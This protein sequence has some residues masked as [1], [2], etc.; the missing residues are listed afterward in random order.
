MNFRARSAAL[1]LA[2]IAYAAIIGSLLPAAAETTKERVL[3][4]G[5]IVIGIHNRAP[6]GYKK[7]GTGELVGWHPD[8]LRAA[9]ADLGVKQIDFEVTEFG[10]LIPGLMAGRFDAVASGLS[11]TPERCKQVAFGGPDL[12]SDD[13]AV[14]LAGNP[15][16]IHSYAD[17]AAKSDLIMG[18]G[19]GS[20]VIKNAITQG[21]PDDR[22]L[23]F[24]DIETNIAALRAGRIDA[25][26]FSSPTVI[27]LLAG[28]KSPDLERANPFTTGDSSISYIA[29]AFRKDDGDLRD[30]Y[31]KGLAKVISSGAIATIMAKYGFGPAEAVPTGL[32]T[33]QLCGSAN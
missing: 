16:A 6:W 21:V 33:A 15:K 31:D 29:I 27:G 28:S 26:V 3:K 9:F 2:C 1:G 25:A 11:I 14:V 8:L 32:T 12:K 22:I 18:G 7:E 17:L 24:P 20:N 30:L 23:Q 19:R 5:R 13:A 10:A 4:D